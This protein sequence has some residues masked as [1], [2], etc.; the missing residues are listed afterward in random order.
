MMGIWSANG[1][2]GNIFGFFLGKL[3]LDILEYRWEYVMLIGAGLHLFMSL[4]VFIVLKEKK[5]D[6][7]MISS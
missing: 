1:D 6:S 4:T 7:D 5:P 2:V 3:V